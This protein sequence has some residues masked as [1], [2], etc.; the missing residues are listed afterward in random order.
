MSLL[1]RWINRGQRTRKPIAAPPV[2]DTDLTKIASALESVIKRL[3]RDHD[4]RNSDQRWERRWRRLEVSGL[5]AAAAVGLTAIIWS[6]VDSERA[7]SVM[8]N[9]LGVM[10]GQLNETQAEQR[11]WVSASAFRPSM[12]VDENTIGINITYTVHNS[13]HSPAVGGLAATSRWV[14]IKDR[15]FGEGLSSRAICG[16]P[17]VDTGLNIFP[18]DSGDLQTSVTIPISWLQDAIVDRSHGNAKVVPIMIGF[19][20]IY[21]ELGPRGKYHHTPYQ[22][23]LAD[24]TLGNPGSLEFTGQPIP[25]DKLKLL[26]MPVFDMM[27]D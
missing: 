21:R 23:R 25:S 8:A 16:G 10:Q 12:T 24:Y 22:F 6:S 7:R 2:A 1:G 4:E 27:P 18:G 13:G 14:I 26:Q 20:L 5:W 3:D 19:C 9:Q 15:S 17:A 11:P